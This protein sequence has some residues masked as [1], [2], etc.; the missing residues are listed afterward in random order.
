MKR[1]QPKMT[2]SAAASKDAESPVSPAD[3]ESSPSPSISPT[4]AL[5]A[6]PPLDRS[7]SGGSDFSGR[8]SGASSRYSTASTSSRRRGYVRPQGATFAESAKNRDSV[9]SL[10]SIAHLQYYFARTGLLDGKGAQ[11]A[12]DKKKTGIS[13]SHVAILDTSSDLPTPSESTFGD[14]SQSPVEEDILDDDWEDPMMLPP[15]VSTYNHREQYIAPPPDT[16]TLRRQLKDSLDH[17]MKALKD[18]REQKREREEDSCK[19]ELY[20]PTIL[21]Q[22]TPDSPLAGQRSP[23]RGWHEIQ[24]MHILDV[25]TLAIRAAKD[26]YTLHEHPHRLSKVKSERQHREELLAVMDVL[27]RM[28]TR[29]FAGGMKGDEVTTVENWVANVKDCL[30]KEKEVEV[31]EHQDRRSWQWLMGNWPPGDHHREWLFLKT[32]LEN[33]EL[34]TW[35][36]IDS[37][38]QLPTPFLKSLANGLTLVCVHNRIL[39]K[40]KRKFGEIKSYHTDTAKPYRAADN[41]RYWLKAAEIRWETKLQLD[42][43]GLVYNK[44]DEVWKQFDHVLLQWCKVVREEVTKEWKAGSVQV[45]TSQL[46]SP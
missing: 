44:G 5:L 37:T 38:T 3:R 46:R 4:P 26:Y 39:K 15:T 16:E 33:E 24:G 32:F 41:L 25:V 9:M 13:D 34:P 35:A 30:R 12:R 8:L 22:P 20:P 7:F 28:G 19:E 42:V 43:M 17:V 6:C 45:G 31:Q 10:G 2:S 14:I 11:L 1:D 23:G 18:V 21:D 27:K 29:H 36:N 40:S